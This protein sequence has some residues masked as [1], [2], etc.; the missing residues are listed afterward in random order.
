[1]V[2][3]GAWCHEVRAEGALRLIEDG[4]AI[5]VATA[6]I[7][8]VG[9]WA[10]GYARG[11]DGLIIVITA[12]AAATAT[13]TF[14]FVLLKWVSLSDGCDGSGMRRGGKRLPIR[15]RENLEWGAQTMALTITGWS[16]R[17]AHR[18]GCARYMVN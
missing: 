2:S 8:A 6:I 16:R 7:N 1:M 12:T 4:A 9:N 17:A 14:L 15:K 18:E 3:G 10:V 11:L 5:A 13:T